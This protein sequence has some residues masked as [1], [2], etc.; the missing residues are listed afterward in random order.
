[1]DFPIDNHTISI[2][3]LFCIVR[4]QRSNFLNFNIFLSLNVV[5]FILEY[6]YSGLVSG[7]L[8][9]AKVTILLISLNL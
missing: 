3:C 1:M 9:L 5:F 4:S 2:H 6:V 8:L 7:S